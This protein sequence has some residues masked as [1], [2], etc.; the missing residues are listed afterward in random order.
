M[1][2]VAREMEEI[3]LKEIGG[4]ISAAT[5]ELSHTSLSPGIAER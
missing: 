4:I 2:G 5:E 1:T 3:G